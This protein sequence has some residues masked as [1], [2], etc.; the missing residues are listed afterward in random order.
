MAGHPAWTA[1]DLLRVHFAISRLQDA[2][3]E[4][5]W[6][7]IGALVGVSGDTARKR[8]DRALKGGQVSAIL[9]AGPTAD[10]AEPDI[11][12][13]VA[14]A[15]GRDPLEV[16]SAM[17]TSYT[18]SHG[19]G[20]VPAQPVQRIRFDRGP[21]CV[22][23]LGDTHLGNGG[24]NYRL[25]REHA[26]IVRST[27]GM[28]LIFLGDL[29][30]NFIFA[31]AAKIRHHTTVTIPE[32]WALARL[33]LSWVA[34]MSLAF[35]DGNHDA[36]TRALAGIDYFADV[37]ASVRP[38]ALYARDDLRFTL[39]V[40][41]AEWEHRLRHKWSGSSIYNPTHGQERGQKWDQDFRVGVG[42]HTHTGAF[43]RTFNAGGQE[44]LAIQVGTY[45][46]YDDYA[47]REGFPRSNGQ[48]PVAVIYTDSGEVVGTSSIERASELM[49]FYYRGKVA[50]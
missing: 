8:Y 5:R 3:Q 16:W 27:P 1:A 18:T 2:G 15:E 22:V 34:P 9:S 30:D 31:W 40:G 26:E 44:G 32:E 6:P 25:L 21:V 23:Y 43:F 7:E 49:R 11:S 47:R 20:R 14:L 17:E 37:V 38:G 41:G 10:P 50:A 36:W 29:I 45:K 24:V 19:V 13:V 42:G 12:G 28:Y 48:Q 46:G 4:P 33:F 35:V 39:D